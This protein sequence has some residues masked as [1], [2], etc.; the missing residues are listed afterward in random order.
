MSRRLVWAGVL[1]RGRGPVCALDATV[2]RPLRVYE[3]PAD[4]VPV[5]GLC[6]RAECLAQPHDEAC[7]GEVGR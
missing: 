5:D 7:H 2:A 4:T 6:G 1:R 3:P